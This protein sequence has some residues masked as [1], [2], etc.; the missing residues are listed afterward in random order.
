MYIMFSIF[1]EPKYYCNV[2]FGDDLSSSSGLFC[3]PE[4]CVRTL[5]PFPVSTPENVKQGIVATFM[6]SLEFRVPSVCHQQFRFPSSIAM[7]PVNEIVPSRQENSGLQVKIPI[8]ER[9]VPIY[10]GPLVSREGD[11]GHYLTKKHEGPRMVSSTANESGIQE[12]SKPHSLTSDSGY[13]TESLSVT[14]SSL[15]PQPQPPGS[16]LKTFCGC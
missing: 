14:S 2:H 8:P 10:R 5:E 11:S 1:Q 6:K 9:P 13:S 4:F 15:P 12:T 16:K 3:Y 7:Q